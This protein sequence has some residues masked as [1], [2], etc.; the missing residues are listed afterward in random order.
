MGKNGKSFMKVIRDIT[1]TLI[2]NTNSPI[3]SDYMKRKVV[4]VF[5][6][7]AVGKSTLFKKIINDIGNFESKKELKIV[8][9]LLNI[10]KNLFIMGKYEEGETFPGTDKLSMSVQPSAVQYIKSTSHNFLIEGDRLSNKKF[11]CEL[12]EDENIELILV[13]LRVSEKT[14]KERHIKRGDNQ[15]DKFLRSRL[16]KCNNIM[17][18]F[19]RHSSFNF[20]YNENEEQQQEIYNF[21]LKKLGI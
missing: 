15:D 20:F 11:F 3:E 21:I 17:N 4:C 18:T 9:G 19:S 1:N 2:I 10:N 14:L 8:C 12:L 7:P 5:G 6:E 13:M 16:T